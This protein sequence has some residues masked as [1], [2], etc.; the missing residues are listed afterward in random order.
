[1]DKIDTEA[2]IGIALKNG[3]ILARVQIGKINQ[4]ELA[5]LINHLEIV[6]D[7]LKLKFRKG[8]KQIDNER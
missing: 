5:M 3:N 1:M 2:K 6:R 8:I 7:D 4:A